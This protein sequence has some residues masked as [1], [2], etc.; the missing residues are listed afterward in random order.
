M[1][2]EHQKNGVLTGP[3]ILTLPAS[4]FIVVLHL[5]WLDGTVQ[6]FPRKTPRL[7]L[8]GNSAENGE[9]FRSRSLERNAESCK[10]VTKEVIE[11]HVLLT[12]SPFASDNLRRFLPPVS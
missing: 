9:G 7:E 10:T 2:N 3:L 1:N 8:S 4:S 6:L 12:R 5:H 11:I